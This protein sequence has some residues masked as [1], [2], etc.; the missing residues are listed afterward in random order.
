MKV[1]KKC[2]QKG[3]FFRLHLRGKIFIFTKQLNSVLNDMILCIAAQAVEAVQ[4]IRRA[5]VLPDRNFSGQERKMCAKIGLF[6]HKKMV[7]M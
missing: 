7:A 2:L 4:T 1:L 5:K 3:L 6:W